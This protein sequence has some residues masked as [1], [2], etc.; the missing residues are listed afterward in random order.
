MTND[1]SSSVVPQSGR[2]Y[3]IDWLRLGAVFLLFFFHTARIFDPHEE[4]YVH[5]NPSSPVLFDTFIRSLGPWHM[6]LSSP[7][8]SAFWCSSRRNRTSGYSTTRTIPSPSSLGSRTSSLCK[9]MTW[10]AISSVDIRGGT[11]GLSSTCLSIRSLLSL[12]SSTSTANPGG[13]SLAGLPRFS[14]SP[15]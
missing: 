9:G 10:T 13:G 4:F 8:S 7:S 6:S 14:R 3:D 11:C 12:S 2:R 5:N 1:G 15:A